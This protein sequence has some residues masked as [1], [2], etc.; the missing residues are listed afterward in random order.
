M[1]NMATCATDELTLQKALN[2]PWTNV[3]LIGAHDT[4]FE[5]LWAAI[6]DHVTVIEDGPLPHQ[7]GATCVV[8]NAVHLTRDQ[9]EALRRRFERGPA[10]RLITL[11]AVPLYP[12][13]EAG[14]FDEILYYRL[15]TITIEFAA[16]STAVA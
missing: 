9:Q 10:L 12:Y 15:N 5:M 3:L 4:H 16:A 2:V 14:Q 6:G 1:R 8:P 11:A 7:L 13:V